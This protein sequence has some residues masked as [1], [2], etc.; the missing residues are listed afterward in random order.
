MSLDKQDEV[1]KKT[2]EVLLKLSEELC[3]EATHVKE[4]I[5]IQV[6][7]GQEA[8]EKRIETL[9]RERSKSHS[10][11]IEYLKGRHKEV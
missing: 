11:H 5:S 4:Q 10:E 1:M 7:A 3:L 9:F 8:L 2:K 6:K